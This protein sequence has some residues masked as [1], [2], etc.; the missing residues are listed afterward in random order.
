MF[1]AKGILCLDAYLQVSSL[2]KLNCFVIDDREARLIRHNFQY[3]CKVFVS[4]SKIA[5]F[6]PSNPLLYLLQERVQ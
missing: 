4:Y 3:L 5:F 6:L 2:C 1:V